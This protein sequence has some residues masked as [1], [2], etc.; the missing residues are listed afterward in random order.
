VVTSWQR[1][2]TA[3]SHTR[4]FEYVTESPVKILTID[5]DPSVRQALAVALKLQWQDVEVLEAADG[6]AGLDLFFESTPDL[7]LLD[8]TM[9][10]MSGFE[11]LR[12]IRLVSDVPVMMISGRGDETDHVR[13]LE[14]GADE[15]L[16]KPIRHAPLLAH[17]LAPV[18]VLPDFVAGELTV[19]YESHE[20]KLGGEVV[21]LTPLEYRLLY[22]LVR[23]AGSL[24]THQ[25]LLDRVWGKDSDVGP[26]YLKVFVS[27]LRT[28]LRRPGRPDL[29]QT[30]RGVGYRFLRGE[31]SPTPKASSTPIGSDPPA[32]LWLAIDRIGSSPEHRDA[33]V[34]HNAARLQELTASIREYG[35]L[36][37]I[38]VVPAGNQ[39]ELVAGSRRLQAA[40]MA[41]LQQI[42]AIVLSDLDEQRQLLVNLVENAQRV[43]LTPT[44]RVRAVR[45]LA[46]AGLGV[47]QVARGTDLSPATI[48]RW[49]RIG[50]NE[51]LLQALEDGR[52]DLFRAMCLAGL[53]EPDALRE[54]IDLAPRYS[55]DDFY[56]LVQQRTVAQSNTARSTARLARQ[57]NT[58]AD[59]LVDTRTPSPELAAPLRRIAESAAA[60]LVQI[61]S[62]SECQPVSLDAVTPGCL[63][64]RHVQ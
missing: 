61:Q 44:E 40:T 7:V 18:E 49:I 10:H 58:I 60:L 20:V 46:A 43:D 23:N 8:V 52:I 33:R 36:E 29:I 38:L 19:N 28:K 57:L 3:A 27:R 16:E 1:S 47:R 22:Q 39:Y 5:D 56:Q 50:A 37:P 53:R 35:V 48:S 15:Y 9:P 64:D 34:R 63:I 42:P 12:Q 54:L 59:R 2:A 11:V 17:M 32:A 14:L 41:G 55:H 4:R 30:E 25:A 21:K 24:L 26:E 62:S 13:G 6:E 51:P 31:R 45:R